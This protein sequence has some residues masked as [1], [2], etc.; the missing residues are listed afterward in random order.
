M[1]ITTS[2]AR[3][4]YTANA[5]QTIFNFTFKIF[6]TTDLNVYVTPAGQECSDSDLTTA[7]FVSDLGDENGGS[8]TFNSA[9]NEGD[10]VTIVSAIPSERTTD[11]QNNGDF[12]PS[13]VNE[14]FDR[15]VSI[16]KKLEDKVNRA[17]ALPECYQGDKPLKIVP[18]ITGQSPVWDGEK[19]INYKPAG[20]L[21]AVPENKIVGNFTNYDFKTVSDA[22]IGLTTGGFFVELEVGN[23][24]FTIGKIS[25]NDG[26][27]SSFVVVP[28]GTG[29]TGDGNYYDTTNGLQLELIKTTYDTSFEL[30]KNYLNAT[31]PTKSVTNSILSI[32]TTDFKPKL[33]ILL[34][35]SNAEGR[36]TSADA[37]TNGETVGNKSSI[38]IWNDTNF[39]DLHIPVNSADPDQNN[40]ALPG[41]FGI[42]LGLSR[43][44]ELNN[45]VMYMVKVTEGGTYMG[46]WLASEDVI[47]VGGGDPNDP[48]N[49]GNLGSSEGVLDNEAWT[50]VQAAV[51]EM[52]SR[53]GVNGWEPVLIMLQ[54]EA[55]GT[56]P[57][58]E[59]RFKRQ[60]ITFNARW[61]T[62]FDSTLRII[63][64]HILAV[65]S[66]YVKIN[67]YMDEIEYEEPLTYV[68]ANTEH[69]QS[70]DNLHLNYFGMCQLSKRVYDEVRTPTA[71]KIDYPNGRVDVIQSAGSFNIKDYTDIAI[72][73]G[74]DAINYSQKSQCREGRVL[75]L[76]RKQSGAGVAIRHNQ[77]DPNIYANFMFIS[78]A[79][80]SLSANTMRK[81]VGYQ[82]HWWEVNLA[83]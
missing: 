55:N 66:D 75:T 48:E 1:T 83:P 9:L 37:T 52:N 44:A 4:E 76:W 24:A 41:R 56:S 36:A 27:S 65:D 15:V 63:F 60:R 46:Q 74:G 39:E 5:G 26:L 80:T 53:F 13:T 2:P 68:I 45:E 6:D 72:V 54:G 3:S 50:A 58:Q 14:D 32:K 7:Y 43:Y 42:E 22:K 21:P 40:D 78:E 73:E 62:R 19:Y 33:A 18:P 82:G 49:D 70:D 69:L 29:V 23:R 20:N 77:G 30:N 67:Q 38:Q 31:N 71:K 61:R 64:S 11:Y 28:A 34:G 79:T 16:V 25:E 12:R 47:P 81:F 57:T 51:T 8:I 59:P 10:L 17:P 35:Q